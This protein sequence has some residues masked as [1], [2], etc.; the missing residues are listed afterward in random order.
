M[1][2]RIVRP[3]SVCKYTPFARAI[4]SGAGAVSIWVYGCHNTARSRSIRLTSET[5]PSDFPYPDAQPPTL[6]VLV[7]RVSDLP[8]HQTSASPQLPPH[9]HNVRS[10][11]DCPC[12]R[13]PP[14][15]PPPPPA[16]SPAPLRSS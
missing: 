12:W 14:S 9:C 2:S 15:L 5:P 4:G 13:R 7:G 11:R 8:L 10:P 16:S 1:P 3:S 6:L